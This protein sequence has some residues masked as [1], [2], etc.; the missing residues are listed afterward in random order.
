M[1]QFML[2][3]T[4]WMDRKNTGWLK[5]G[6]VQ[7]YHSMEELL[8]KI[9]YAVLQLKVELLCCER[10]SYMWFKHS[11]ICSCKLYWQY[12]CTYLWSSSMIT[13]KVVRVQF[14]VRISTVYSKFLPINDLVFQFF[15]NYLHISS[16]K[17]SYRYQ[18]RKY[19]QLYVV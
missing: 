17:I 8:V 4:T 12:L 13:G 2:Y 10:C 16:Y 9:V 5:F 6:T 1:S 3:L 15:I 11:D 18:I 7:G 14:P 19:V